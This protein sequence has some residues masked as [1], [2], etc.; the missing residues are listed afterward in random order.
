[1]ARAG[2]TPP[3]RAPAGSPHGESAELARLAANVTRVPAGGPPP[4]A[5]PAQPQAQSPQPAPGP[6]PGGPPA[7]ASD[8]SGG[9]DQAL[10]APT[11]RPD[12]PITHGAPFGPGANFVQ[13]PSED[14]RTFALRVAGQLAS[15]PGLAPFVA[16]IQQGR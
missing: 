5:T 16:A 10:F 7:P 9:Y 4:S 13:A 6:T 8:L 12:E 14:N 15:D 11:Q 1:M 3:V 2:E